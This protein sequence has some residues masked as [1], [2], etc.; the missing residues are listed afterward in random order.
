MTKNVQSKNS[1]IVECGAH[2]CVWARGFMHGWVYTRAEKSRWWRH[3]LLHGWAYR[4]V[5][6][7]TE[8][9]GKQLAIRTRVTVR[10]TVCD[11]V[12]AK[13]KSDRIRVRPLVFTRQWPRVPQWVRPGTKTPSKKPSHVL[14]MA[15]FWELFF[16]LLLK[17]Y[18]SFLWLQ[19]LFLPWK[20]LIITRHSAS[21][22]LFRLKCTSASSMSSLRRTFWSVSADSSLPTAEVK[23]N[24]S[25]WSINPIIL[26]DGLPKEKK[27]NW[28]QNC[29]SLHPFQA[30]SALTE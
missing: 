19:C 23:S 28:P 14:G 29:P 2:I 7:L 26:H 10:V 24:T 12:S 4:R 25:P 30:R 17:D 15:D 3:G 9:Y 8:F 13:C 27:K 18:S 1:A 22:F 21:E 16:L 20:K 11:W 6:L 5:G